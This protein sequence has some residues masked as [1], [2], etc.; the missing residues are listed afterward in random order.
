MLLTQ[1]TVDRIRSFDG[2]GHPI[3]SVYLG[4]R[5]GVGELRSLP[6]RLK[7]VMAPVR[8]TLADLPRDSAMSLRADIEAVLAS[9]DHISSDRGRGVALFR[10]S[11]AGID[12]YVS[13]PGPVRDRAVTDFDPYLRPLDAMLE[14]YHSYCAVVIDRR[15]SSIFRFRMG[16]LETWEEMAEEEVRKQNYGGFSG[17]EEGKSRNRAEEIAHRHYRDTAHR[18]RELD[19]QEP[20]DL[21]L[22]GGPADHVDG[23]TT[24]LDPTLRSKLAGSFALDPG[25]MTPAAVRSHCEELSAAYDR[26]HEAEVVTGLLDRA[27]SSPLAAVGVDPV[28]GAVNQRA[29]AELVVQGMSSTPG[30]RCSDCGWLVTGNGA[31]CPACGEGMRAVPDLLDAMASAVRRSGGSVQNVITQTPLITYEV[32]AV[33]RYA[34]PQVEPG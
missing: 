20:F 27:G 22:V 7:D 1:E 24:A 4:L 29:V 9:T 11:A 14:H 10:C 26:K 8:T 25:T 18:L 17:Y 6:P 16:E 34:V 15:K 21:L 31:L 2:E 19:Q 5:P 13:L 33:L 32:G 3:L 30:R 23:L 12:E 28:L